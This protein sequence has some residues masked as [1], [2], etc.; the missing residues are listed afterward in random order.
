MSVILEKYPKS[1]F[2][3]RV[4]PT[5]NFIKQ[6]VSAE[7]KNLDRLVLIFCNDEEL[8]KIN[9]E[10]LRHDTL[11]DIITFDYTEGK[12]ISGEIYISLDRIKE[13]AKKFKVS[14]KEELIR[15]MAHGLLHLCGYKD[16][17]NKEKEQMKKKENKCLRLSRHFLG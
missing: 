4:I 7:K 17:T 6:I 1:I 16:K 3:G 10:F 8:L 12:V 14:E 2:K 11:T 13:N 5:K 15:V 9:R